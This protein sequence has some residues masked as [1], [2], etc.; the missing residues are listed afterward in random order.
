MSKLL[1]LVFLL[2]L[3]Y[4]AIRFFWNICYISKTHKIIEANRLF[5][6]C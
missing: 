6:Y 5:C 4:V 1:L 2:I 3:T